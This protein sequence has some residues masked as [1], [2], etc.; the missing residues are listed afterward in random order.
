MKRYDWRVL[1]ACRGIDPELFFPVSPDGPS[2][3]EVRRA[4]AVCGDC[5]VRRECLEF[6]LGTG[7]RHGVWG[8]LTE[9]E[10]RFLRVPRQRNPGDGVRRSA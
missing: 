3:D 1:A 9:D 5:V 6:A 2:L 10:R 4:K 7:Q 8:G